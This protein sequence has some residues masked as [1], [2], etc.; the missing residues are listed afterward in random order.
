MAWAFCVAVALCAWGGRVVGQNDER[1]E[2]MMTMAKNGF[3]FLGALL[4]AGVASAN[5]AENFDWGAGVA[6][7]TSVTNG[8][9]INGLQ[10]E[11]GTTAAWSSPNAGGF[12]GSEGPGNGSHTL[13]DGVQN[14]SKMF[15]ELAPTGTVSVVME[16]THDLIGSGVRGIWLGFTENTSPLFNTDTYDKVYLRAFDANSTIGVTAYDSVNAIATRNSDIN[17]GTASVSAGDLVRVSLV[18]DMDA[19]MMRASVSNVT[20]NV[21][22]FSE[23]VGWTEELNFT[24]FKIDQTGLNKATIHSLSITQIPTPF[25]PP[26]SIEEDFDWGSGVAG[27]TSIVSG[28]SINNVQVQSGSTWLWS[29]TTGT[30]TAFGGSAG[31]GNGTLTLQGQNA[32]IRTF[33]G[34]ADGGFSASVTGSYD[35]F[36]TGAVRGF[37]MGFQ[38]FAYTSS[39]ITNDTNDNFMAVINPTNLNLRVRIAGTTTAATVDTNN[40]ALAEGDLLRMDVVLDMQ[41]KTL[42]AAYENLTQVGKSATAEV[43]WSAAAYVPLVRL[44]TVQMTGGGRVV[45]D[46]TSVAAYDAPPATSNGTP[47]AWLD[48]YYPGLS[49]PEDYENADLDD[50]DGDGL[51]AWQEYIAGTVPTNGGSVFA[52]TAAQSSIGGFVLTWQSAAGRSY[53]VSTNQNLVFPQWGVE[54]SGIPGQDG[55]TA[56]TTTAANAAGYFKVEV[57]QP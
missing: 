7:R 40:W 31:L 27:R 10:V 49:T 32:Y 21:A 30:N 26:E 3:G 18:L 22:V 15:F 19:K 54:A 34:S 29:A 13:G 51:A 42:A 11:S 16:Y 25:V 24:H 12:A 33:S 28:Q 1:E 2:E 5:V 46:S 4:A 57:Q 55:T 37:Y 17:F 47:Y 50:G 6:G 53:A 45:L 41:N 56:Y 39:L 48:L 44:F 38:T 52:F 20:D 43:D 8:Q 14:N 9:S 35:S 36:G 23:L